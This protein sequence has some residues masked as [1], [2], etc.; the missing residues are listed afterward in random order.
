[1]KRKAFLQTSAAVIGSSLLPSFSFAGESFSDKLHKKPLRF[2]H[3]TDIHVKPGPIPEAG[4]TKAFQHAQQL[5]PGVDFIINGGDSIM[6][7]L[8]AGKDKTQQQWD[9]FHRILKNENSLPIYHCIGNHD[10]WGW[11]VNQNLPAGQAGK[12][13]NDRLYGKV[14]AVETLQLPNR[15]YSFSKDKWHFIVLDSVQLNPA[16]GY[17]G[18]LDPD[19][20]DWLQ[21]ELAR[22]PMDKFI[23]IVSHIPVL[24]ICAGLFFDKTE[25]NGDLKIQRNLMHS[26]FL[27]LKKIFIKYP[28]IKVCIS[29][30]IHLQDEVDYLGIRYYCDGAVCGNWWSGAFQEFDPAYALIELYDDGSSKRTMMKYE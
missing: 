22:V 12:P 2:A 13:D 23:C 15:F 26:D 21:Q 20:L 14:W 11:F 28:N 30:H 27:A 19:Q 24:S 6:D 25:T 10:I 5:K 29:G 8:E 4:M 9:L 18:R 3:I 17:I 7:A 1:M 16:G